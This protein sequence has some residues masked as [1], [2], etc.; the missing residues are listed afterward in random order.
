MAYIKLN[1]FVFDCSKCHTRCD[2]VSKSSYIFNNDVI[3]SERFEEMLIK[4]IN[5]PG[6]Y[7]AEKTQEPGYPDLKLQDQDKNLYCY[8]EVKVQQRTFMQVKKY[9][10]HS[11]LHP[12]ET[13]ALNLSDLLR[14]FNIQKST[15]IPTVIVWFLLNR[16]CVVDKDNFKVYFQFCDELE[17]IYK[18]EKDRRIF[19]RKS[20]EG[21]VTDGVHKGVTVNYHFR[22]A[23]LKEWK[24]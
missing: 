5:K 16:L 18:V 3:F 11:N 4:R 15:K 14:Y 20:G 10:P 12:S 23:E 21:D 7:S 17:R 2:G 9:L 22:L 19:K 13:V 1:D 6:K 24:W 8:V